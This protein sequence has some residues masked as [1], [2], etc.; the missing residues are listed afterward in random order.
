M[1]TTEVLDAVGGLASYLKSYAAK[2]PPIVHLSTPSA[3]LK[4]SFEAVDSYE[5]IVSRVRSQSSGTPYKALNESLV[6][7]LE[8]FEIGNLIGAVQPL[9]SALDHLERMQRDK[10]IEMG[11]MDE[12]RLH[13][14]RAGLHKVLPGN[15]PELD[16]PGQ[17]I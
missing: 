12:K 13:E 7:S 9:L 17:R 11:R 2:L 15:K 4:P 3:G 6:S 16:G 1:L 5:T 8:A 14:Y 10:E